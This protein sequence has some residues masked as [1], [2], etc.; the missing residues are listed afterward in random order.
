[1]KRFSEIAS[2]LVSTLGK[3]NHDYGDSFY[4]IYAKHGDFSTM[5]RLQDKIGRLETI[6]SGEELLVDDEPIEDIYLDIAGYC[7]L[8]LASKQRLLKEGGLKHVDY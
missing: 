8:S 1:M 4:K 3:K 7:I 2:K 5:I 6:V